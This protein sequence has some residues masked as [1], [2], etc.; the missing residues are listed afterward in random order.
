[1]HTLPG[2]LRFAQLKRARACVVGRLVVRSAL[3]AG[4]RATVQTPG[5][6]VRVRAADS[7]RFFRPSIRLA[8]PDVRRTPGRGAQP[9]TASTPWPPFVG[10]TSHSGEGRE[11]FWLGPTSTVAARSTPP[12]KTE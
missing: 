1:M 7:R 11:D 8:P 6:Q 9:E 2:A 12:M 3:V 10:E 4:I 5:V